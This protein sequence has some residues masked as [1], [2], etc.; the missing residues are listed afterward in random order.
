VNIA[1]GQFVASITGPRSRICGKINGKLDSLISG[2]NLIL[3]NLSFGSDDL[4]YTMNDSTGE[5]TLEHGK[6]MAESLE[7]IPS[8]SL[9]R[10][11]SNMVID[12]SLHCENDLNAFLAIFNLK[13]E[14][15]LE[16]VNPDAKASLNFKQTGIISAT[17]NPYTE[18]DF[19]IRDA[20]IESIRLPY[21]VS[22]LNISGNYNNGAEHKAK[23]ACIRIDTLHAR[24]EDSFIDGSAVISDLQS[25]QILAK[26]DAR[27]DLSQII[28]PTSLVS[29]SGLIT[30]KFEIKGNLIDLDKRGIRE[31]D[32]A[33]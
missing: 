31:K 16:Q 19:M 8:F 20:K 30:A 18:L 15:D 33:A 5:Q 10:K 9:V 26:F 11:D 32:F 23:S 2:G 17:Q 14:K 29:A 7:I 28:K 24:I 12:F 4:L 3:S 22:G 27:F 13:T 25:P 6:I 21:P 1:E